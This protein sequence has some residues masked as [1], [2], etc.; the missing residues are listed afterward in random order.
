MITSNSEHESDILKMNLD[1]FNSDIQKQIEEKDLTIGIFL[2][3]TI[4]TR[5][6]K[7]DNNGE[8]RNDLGTECRVCFKD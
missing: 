4:D 5:N 8:G 1:F 3:L 2:Y 7:A 6:S